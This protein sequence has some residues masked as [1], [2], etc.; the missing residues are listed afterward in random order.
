MPIKR[1]IHQSF[2]TIFAYC[3]SLTNFLWYHER[4]ITMVSSSLGKHNFLFYIDVV[5]I[6]WTVIDY[7]ITFPSL[8]LFLR[9]C[10]TARMV[11]RPTQVHSTVISATISPLL[12]VR[13]V[14]HAWCAFDGYVGIMCVRMCTCSWRRRR[15]P[16][17]LLLLRRKPVEDLPASN[18]HFILGALRQMPGIERA[19]PVNGTNTPIGAPHVY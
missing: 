10:Q 15:L 18:I 3:F 5:N 19:A 1:C 6:N 2:F 16:G 14:K 4:I 9:Y 12:I 8:M 13:L 11:C 7:F 17:M